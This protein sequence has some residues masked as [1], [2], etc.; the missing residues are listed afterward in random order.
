MIREEREKRFERSPKALRRRQSDGGERGKC[1][2]VEMGKWESRSWQTNFNVVYCGS[3]CWVLNLPLATACVLVCV[4]EYLCWPSTEVQPWMY[5]MFIL[6]L[7]VRRAHINTFT[8]GTCAKHLV[9]VHAFS[10]LFL[11]PLAAQS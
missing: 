10:F 6:W 7:R 9:S 3:Q 4:S 5:L 2:K 1:G 11:P 8:Y